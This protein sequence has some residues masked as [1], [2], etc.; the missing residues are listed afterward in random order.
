M[1]DYMKGPILPTALSENPYR[2]TVWHDDLIDTVTGEVLEEG[3]TFWAEYANNMEWGIFNNFEQLIHFQRMIK[4]IQMQ[5]ELDGRVPG[6]NGNFVDTFDELPTRMTRLT[7]ETNVTAAVTAGDTVIPVTDANQFDVLQLVTVYDA[8]SYEHLRINTVDKE[9]N[10]LTV[11]AVLNDYN[12]GAKVAR[13]TAAI[14]DVN[15]SMNF[16]TWGTYTVSVS[17]VV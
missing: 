6:A 2:R 5:L 15:N 1:A 8:D 7:S 16:G 17:E 11:G 9:A 3:T 13:S 12:K 14:D 4:K 10:K